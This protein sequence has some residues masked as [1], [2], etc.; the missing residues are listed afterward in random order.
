MLIQALLVT[1]IAVLGYWLGAEFV[2]NSTYRYVSWSADMPFAERD[3]LMDQ[4]MSVDQHVRYALILQ[5]GL[6]CSLAILLG[7]FP[8]D[9]RLAGL[10]GGLAVIWLILVETTHRQRKA[11]GGGTLATVDRGIRYL[12]AGLLLVAGI[13]ASI[14]KLALPAWLAWKLILFALVICCGLAVRFALIRFYQV[15]KKV[16]AEEANRDYEREIRR[17][18]FQATAILV[19][20]WSCIMSI[21]VLSVWKP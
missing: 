12:I 10:A 20:L 9:G 18:Y 8:G 19:L 5:M 16:A 6:G 14:G 3:R 17:I 4:V 15:W 7:Y 21:V 11:A 13:G 2:I 1:H